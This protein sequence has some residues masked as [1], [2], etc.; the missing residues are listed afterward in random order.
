MT[1]KKRIRQCKK[2][3]VK[4]GF[5]EIQAYGVWCSMI[6]HRIK[7][8]LFTVVL[9]ATVAFSYPATFV[10]RASE[11]EE[12]QRIQQKQ[13]QTEQ[14]LEDTNARK[15]EAQQAVSNLQEDAQET[16]AQI[17]VTTSRLNTLYASIND[18]NEQ[19]S[20]TMDGIETLKSQLAEAENLKSEQY[21]RLKSRIAYNYE[22]TA[23]QNILTAYL[24]SGTFADFLKRVDYMWAAAQYDQQIISDYETIEADIEK[25]ALELSASEEELKAFKE[26]LSASQGELSSLLGIEISELNQTNGQIISTKNQIDNY[27]E[28]IT[29]LQNQ[30]KDLE[31]QQAAAQAALAKRIAEEQEAERKRAAAKAAEEA[32]KKAEEEIRKRVEEEVRRQA[33][34][35]ARKKA[36]EE[37]QA[38]FE[39]AVAEA[40]ANGT[41]PPTAPEEV[42]EVTVDEAS[43]AA[44]IEAR[45]EAELAGQS[46]DDASYEVYEDTGGAYAADETE[47]VLLAATIQAEAGNQSYTGKLAVGSVIMNRVKSSKFPNTIYGVITQEN[48][49]EPWRKGIVTKFIEAGPNETCMEIARAVCNG[50]RNGNWLF[51]MTPKWAEYYGIT[52]YTTI[53]GHAFFYKWGAN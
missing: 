47:I 36:E 50:S 18:T 49:F 17:N 44:K 5:C 3:C 16:Q 7:I 29:S 37:A 40:E 32:R 43:V 52:G 26:Q 28:Q 6:Q 27:D 34:E 38:A 45:V 48:Q 19:I 9:A 25:K 31:A 14:Q 12:I 2:V 11:E 53:G 39:Q 1:H 33:E 4:A 21:N 22:M 42:G 23:G 41:E 35:E 13:Q 24:E 15:A 8:R 10:S 51:F 20:E 30:M 46:F